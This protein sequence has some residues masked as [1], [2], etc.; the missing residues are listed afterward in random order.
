VRRGVPGR[1]LD[2]EPAAVR[3]GDDR[4][5]R[6]TELAVRAFDTCGVEAPARRCGPDRHVATEE[7]QRIGQERGVFEFNLAGIAPGSTINSA[8]FEFEVSS[9][10]SG[11]AG[12]PQLVIRAFAG[13]GG[14]RSPTE[15][16]PRPWREPEA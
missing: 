4:G 7:R 1:E 6:E 9:F 16:R 8:A 15:T 10:T 2:R 5:D 3:Q 11:S 14:S 13:D 12:D